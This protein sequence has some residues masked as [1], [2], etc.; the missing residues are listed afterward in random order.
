MAARDR[1]QRGL[2]RGELPKGAKAALT[3]LDRARIP[4]GPCLALGPLGVLI[5]RYEVKQGTRRWSDLRV[6]SEGA[7]DRDRFFL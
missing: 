2:A 4:R 1:E 3:P 5:T 6:R 7:R